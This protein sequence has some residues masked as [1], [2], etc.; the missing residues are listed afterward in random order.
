MPLC[1]F[2]LFLF[3]RLTIRLSMKLS[4]VT[5]LAAIFLLP[6]MTWSQNCADSSYHFRYKFPD[7][8]DIHRQIFLSDSGRLVEGHFKSDNGILITRF[9]KFS[10]IV[11]SK[12]LIPPSPYL[13][14]RIRSLQE[15][16]N[17][18]LA[19][20][21]YLVNAQN[22]F[23]FYYAFLSPL[24]NIVSQKV[25][26][27][28][29]IPN[30]NLRYN[31]NTLVFKKGAD[32]LVF[33]T[34]LAWEGSDPQKLIFAI[35]DQA[36]NLGS[37]RIIHLPNT[38]TR[39]DIVLARV[40]GEKMQLFGSAD[41]SS[42]CVSLNRRGSFINIEIDLLSNQILQQKTYCLPMAGGDGFLGWSPDYHTSGPNDYAG[43]HHNGFFLDNG[44]IALIR[45]FRRVTTIPDTTNWL[46]HISYFDSFFN[47]VSSELVT[48]GNI[49]INNTIQEVVIDGSQNK[50]FYFTDFN[51]KRTYYARANAG[52]EWKF[53][54]VVQ[55]PLLGS[56]TIENRL[57]LPSTNAWLTMNIFSVSQ[58][59]SQI[60][61]F[62]LQEKDTATEC[63]G[64]DTSFLSFSTTQL[65]AG[66]W[67]A[68]TIRLVN[69]TE[70]NL[71]F[72]TNDYEIGKEIVCLKRRIC[73]FINLMTPDAICDINN[74]V[75]ITARINND[76]EAS[77]LFR[78]DT[79]AVTSYSQPDD[80]TLLLMFDKTWS[81][82]IYGALSSCP[83][84]MDTIELNVLAP[85]SLSLG[86]DTIL[87]PGETLQLTIPGYTQ[88][89]WQNNSTQDNFLITVPGRYYLEATDH[90]GRNY[91]DTIIVSYSS[92]NFNVGPD[93]TVC[94]GEE[95]QISLDPS[96]S[97]YQWQP[98]YNVVTT[99]LSF[100]SVFPHK[101]TSYEI[102]AK[103]VYD[104]ILKDSLTIKIDTCNTDLYVPTAFTPNGDGTNDYF[105]PLVK[106][107]ILKYQFS[108]YN[109]WGQ[110]VF[111][112]N[113]ISDGWNGY[114]TN[115]PQPTGVFVWTCSFQFLNERPKQVKGTVLLIR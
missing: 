113:K 21:G 111:S 10:E 107:F 17:G 33:M 38:S 66:T 91:S 54:R 98:N 31:N 6:L 35:T 71:T 97:N 61:Y 3:V 94:L 92:S 29:E 59:E 22:Q 27:L 20:S 86:N 43:W 84:V 65:S 68:A 56:G 11:W 112:T 44:G 5:I 79:A 46:F 37:K 39:I 110:L 50:H 25:L 115:K 63:F 93:L 77:V 87:C 52:N 70:E 42:S 15:T 28:P 57:N 51:S 72:S 80:T 75:K 74:P 1:F 103:D 7:A 82:K 41:H 108:I 58:T 53:Q 23:E 90:C 26:T 62:S 40:I 95:K 104:C 67:G 16:T 14:S 60:D 69:I 89:Q 109:R 24:G 36:G 18:N 78:F 83:S 19:I 96:F 88:Y 102:Q 64:I 45:A 73:D 48:T 13:K 114:V 99:G 76:C 49:F 81:G 55:V 106:G 2:C 4:Y 101:T 30:H 32:S 105:K 8:L 47:P 85:Q 100:F 34:G 12:K 9:N